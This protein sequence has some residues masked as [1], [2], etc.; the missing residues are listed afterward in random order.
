MQVQNKIVNGE[1]N[2]PIEAASIVIIN[3]AGRQMPGGTSSGADGS[4]SLNLSELDKP[5]RYIQVSSA[6]YDSNVFYPDEWNGQYPF[7]LYPGKKTILDEVIVKAKKVIKAIIPEKKPSMALPLA[8]LGLSLVSL[9]V[10]FST[11][12]D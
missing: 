2:E 10:S 4:F 5:D 11:K 6:G 8:L 12:P 9:V 7:K 1:T 3:G